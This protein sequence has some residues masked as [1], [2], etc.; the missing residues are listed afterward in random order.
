M[1][2]WSSLKPF[3]GAANKTAVVIA[4]RDAA[5]KYPVSVSFCAR[6]PHAPVCLK[7]HLFSKLCTKRVGFRSG[8]ANQLTMNVQ[9]RSGS[10]VAGKWYGL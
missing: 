8:L 9:I 5:T 7:M 4:Q 6:G 2:D 10:P 3:E 1:D